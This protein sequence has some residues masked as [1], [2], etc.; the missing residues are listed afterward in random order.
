MIIYASFKSPTFLVLIGGL[1]NALMLP[2]MAVSALYFRYKCSDPR[3]APNKAWDAFLAISALGLIGSYIF[4]K[5]SALEN[6]NEVIKPHARSAFRRLLSLYQ[7]LSR[8]AFTIDDCRNSGD[9]KLTVEKLESIVI[10]QLATADDAIEDW[11]D[12]VPAEVNELKQNR[13]KGKS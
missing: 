12:I 13:I 9:Y 10:E 6:A 8:V 11:A 5:N 7:S 2:V 1:L 4:G 3:V